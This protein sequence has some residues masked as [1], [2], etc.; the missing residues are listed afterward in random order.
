[1]KTFVVLR[2]SVYR[3]AFAVLPAPVMLTVLVGT[4]FFKP[5][6]IGWFRSSDSFPL[7]VT[8]VYPLFMNHIITGDERNVKNLEMKVYMVY[9][10]W[11]IFFNDGQ[12][13]SQK[14][15]LKHTLLS[16]GNGSQATCRQSE[17]RIW[18]GTLPPAKGQNLTFQN[19]S[20]IYLSD[21]NHKHLFLFL[22]RRNVKRV[23]RKALAVHRCYAN[24]KHTERRIVSGDPPHGEFEVAHCRR[25]GKA[26][27]TLGGGT[28]GFPLGYNSEAI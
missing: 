15:N 2:R 9:V 26:P 5:K 23:C 11:G 13:S 3:A 16:A 6:P 27:C 24:H 20:T 1:M 21:V 7:T 10:S 12:I 8:I 4:I 17:R 28:R 22:F 18:S 25:H 14:V 19:K